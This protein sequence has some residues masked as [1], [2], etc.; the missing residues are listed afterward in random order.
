MAKLNQYAG[1]AGQPLI[2]GNRVYPVEILVPEKTEQEKFARCLQQLQLAETNS[3][4]SAE[5][6]DI[7]FSV[8]LHRAFSG[9]LTSKWREAHMKELLQEMELQAKE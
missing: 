4:K 3:M 7:L 1:R 9:D 2:S 6:L 5:Q 8:L